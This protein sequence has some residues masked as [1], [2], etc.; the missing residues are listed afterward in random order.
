MQI[1]KH[2]GIVLLIGLIS[3]CATTA[4]ELTPMEI[5]SMQTRS[6]EEEKSIVFGSVVSVFQDLGYQIDSADLATG[7]ITS[8][9][10][11]DSVSSWATALTGMRQVTQTRATA[12]VEEVGARVNVRLNFLVMN[13][14]SGGYGQSDRQDQP[15]T[16]VEIY[17]NAFERIENAIFVRSDA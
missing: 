12:F 15:I 9:S 7:L 13:Q 1:K 11:A 2:L 10:P 5:Q 14:L 8:E 17:Q 6:F 3:G 4:P 16:D